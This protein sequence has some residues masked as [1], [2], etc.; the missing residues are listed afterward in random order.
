MPEVDEETLM[1]RVA[2]KK[3]ILENKL[4]EAIKQVESYEIKEQDKQREKELVFTLKCLKIVGLI[5]EGKIEQ[6]LT[7]AR[8]ELLP[9]VMEEVAI[10]ILGPSGSSESKKS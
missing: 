4:D 10:S 1:K 2:I 5:K 3:L 9:H 6:A 7:T 8:E